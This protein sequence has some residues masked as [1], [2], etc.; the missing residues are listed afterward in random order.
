MYVCMY[1][2]MNVNYLGILYDDICACL[3]R[4]PR[5]LLWLT[6]AGTGGPPWVLVF[7]AF[8]QRAGHSYGLGW[9]HL[10]LLGY[11]AG[12]ANCNLQGAQGWCHERE[13]LH[14]RRKYI[15]FRVCWFHMQGKSLCTLVSSVKVTPLFFSYFLLPDL[16]H[17]H[18]QE[19]ADFSW[20]LWWRQF[21]HFFSRWQCDWH[22]VGWHILS[23]L[24]H[25]LRQWT[26]CLWDS[27]DHFWHHKWWV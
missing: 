27:E 1:V 13:W 7:S 5:L 23:H 22:R 20:S 11:R 4:V 10:Q 24:W 18:W 16:G 17:S 9:L 19:R 8:R 15:R 26:G 14:H 25:A 6:Y 3:L 21:C 2:C 12:Q